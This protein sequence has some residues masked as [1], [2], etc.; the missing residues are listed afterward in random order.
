MR[1][2]GDVAAAAR[3][4]GGLRAERPALGD[5]YDFN[6]VLSGMFGLKFQFQTYSDDS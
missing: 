1:G 2:S 5:F 6:D 3:G 4:I